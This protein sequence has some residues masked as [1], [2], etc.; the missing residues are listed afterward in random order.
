MGEPSEEAAH[1]ARRERAV[2]TLLLL[3]FFAG[4]YFAVASAP[5]SANARTLAFALD[6]RIPFV[7]E[8]VFV[9]VLVYS[10]ALSP[11]FLVR[12][13]RLFR[14]T[15]LA[16]AVA[17]G[18]ALPCFLL[19]PVTSMG[20]RPPLETLDPARFVEWGV[21][22]LY[23]WDPPLNLFPSLH[24][25]LAVLAG[26]AA[27]KAQPAAG[28]VALPAVLMI[29]VSVCTVKQHFLVDVLAGTALA[30]AIYTAVLRPYRAV[31]AA[32][33]AYSWRGPVGFL[34]LQVAV[35]LGAFVAFR[36]GFAPWSG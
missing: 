26:L 21:M 10:A 3:S 28:A 16:F 15:A 8:S 31:G 30:L 22:L 32:P 24:I 29:A 20:L 2:L 11:L 6:G 17:I 27:W 5:N 25:A 9:Y 19:W 12:C 1:G 13:R 18:L 33:T 34:A 35:F 14:R 7:P 36:N 23:T 4:G